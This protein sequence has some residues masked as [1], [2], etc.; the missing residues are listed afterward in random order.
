MTPAGRR[1]PSSS[2]FSPPGAML[3]A[4]HM[5]PRVRNVELIVRRF[6]QQGK[7]KVL[8]DV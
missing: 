2:A 8:I 7:P 4:Q 3:A 5:L 6:R 1:E